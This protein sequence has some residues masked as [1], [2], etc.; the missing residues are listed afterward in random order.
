MIIP[1]L[2]LLPSAVAGARRTRLI[3]R[4]QLLT[5][6]YGDDG[7]GEANIRPNIDAFLGP[8]RAS[9][10]PQ[11]DF[12]NNPLLT[13]AR[14]LSTPGLYASGV[15]VGHALAS[16]RKLGELAG[17]WGYWLHM[18]AMQFLT[19]GIGDAFLHLSEEEGR[20][21]FREV[22]AHMVEPDLDPT[23]PTRVRVWREMRLR[24]VP[25]IGLTWAWDVYDLVNRASPGFWIEL[26]NGQRDRVTSLI[27]NTPDEGLH[28][29]DYPWRYADGTPYAPYVH[30]ACAD[31]GRF[32]HD[33]DLR[34]LTRT[35]L[36][37]MAFGTMA[38]QSA[39]D[40]SH[41][42]AIAVGV[43]LPGM[44]SDNSAGGIPAARMAI[45]PGSILAL[46]GVP[47]QQAMIT[48]LRP[49]ADLPQLRLWMASQESAVLSRMGLS[50]DDVQFFS[51]NPT[52]A[53]SLSI[54]NRAKR[55]ISDRVAP[56]FRASDTAALKMMAALLG[57]YPEAG[58]SVVYHQ[59]PESPEEENARLDAEKKELDLRLVSRVQL[60]QRHHPGTTREDAIRAL[61]QVEADEKALEPVEEAEEPA[62]MS[63]TEG[64]TEDE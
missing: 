27:P 3:I 53:E 60:Y 39:M 14:Q 31:P 1:P 30:Y 42:T 45:L 22:P 58:Y 40:S 34:G 26:P 32:W 48:Q 25:G 51:A 20:I 4:R 36:G 38:N 61:Q 21:C 49:S 15:Q 29:A 54:R 28:G 11:V 18:Q 16:G 6:D 24:D 2:P 59:I 12:S 47:D 57:G 13:A 7:T 23:D 17:E 62:E 9:L 50:T 46:D 33:N 19:V 63:P 37:Q 5:Q 52:S 35:T 10:I 8:E 43:Q 64:E 41:S 44:P 55:V 56:Y